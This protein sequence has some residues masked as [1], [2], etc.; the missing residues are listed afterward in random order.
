MEQSVSLPAY[1]YIPKP[2]EQQLPRHELGTLLEVYKKGWGRDRSVK[3]QMLIAI[4]VVLAIGIVSSIGIFT[5]VQ[6]THILLIWLLLVPLIAFMV[7]VMAIPSLFQTSLCVCAFSNGL[8]YAKNT[9]VTL[10]CW[11]EIERIEQQ[12]QQNSLTR[13]TSRLYRI[14]ARDGR[15]FEVTGPYLL[16]DDLGKIIGER[17]SLL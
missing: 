15:I 14:Y 2:I 4:V 9:Q 8:I 7:V 11:N 12:T 13:A 10:L 3:L 16:V 17:I 5:I 6:T 1:M